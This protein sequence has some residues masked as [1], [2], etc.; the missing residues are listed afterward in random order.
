[1][2]VP[3]RPR[4]RASRRA[5]FTSGSAPIWRRL[6]DQVRSPQRSV[7]SRAG[8]PPGVRGVPAASTRAGECLLRCGGS[9]GHEGDC[10]RT[11]RRGVRHVGRA[12][13][14]PRRVR[15]G[16]CQTVGSQAPRGCPRG[17]PPAGGGSRGGGSTDPLGRSGASGSLPPGL[18][19]LGGEFRLAVVLY[20]I[21]G[22][23]YS[24]IA[25]LTGV[26]EGTVKSR[27]HRGRAQLRESL[28]HRAPQP[29]TTTTPTKSRTGMIRRPAAGVV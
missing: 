13:G 3:C 23:P 2:S 20:D 12:D 22:C 16:G 18:G 29:S 4:L 25:E 7:A 19:G 9:R 11:G 14:R 15:G 6:I 27:I 21:L 28:A 24:E 8:R 17:D 5:P 1:M 26:A 10:V